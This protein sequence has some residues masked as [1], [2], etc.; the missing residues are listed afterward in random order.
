MGQYLEIFKRNFSVLD[1]FVNESI[2]IKGSLDRVMIKNKDLVSFVNQV[3]GKW[4]VNLQDEMEIYLIKHNNEPLSNV[5]FSSSEEVKEEE[6]KL[7]FSKEEK[8]DLFYSLA[9]QYYREGDSDKCLDLLRRLKDKYLLDKLLNSF[10]Y[11]ERG[12]LVESLM[13]SAVVK[14]VRFLAAIVTG[15]L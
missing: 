6:S 14:S 12:K 8:E 7:E 9:S 10:T 15:K 2:E 11:N 4:K 5:V 13:E 1:G 3:D